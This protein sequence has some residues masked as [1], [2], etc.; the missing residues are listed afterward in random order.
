MQQESAVHT[1]APNAAVVID[2]SRLPAP[3]A[4]PHAYADRR[5]RWHR[6][7]FA[8]APEKHTA[9]ELCM[10]APV[11]SRTR[12]TVGALFNG[13]FLYTG[14]IGF[15]TFGSHLGVGRSGT[16]LRPTTVLLDLAV[17]TAG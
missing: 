15:S 12:Q 17:R 3:A 16:Q 1:S 7:A 8:E 10:Q 6:T 11:A 13:S 4:A 14:T 5:I 2:R 9:D